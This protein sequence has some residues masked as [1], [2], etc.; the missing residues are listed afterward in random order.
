VR[1][2][3]NAGG[4]D[5][6]P[7]KDFDAARIHQPTH[8]PARSQYAHSEA[9]GQ[10]QKRIA[11]MATAKQSV[12]GP[13]DFEA[14]VRKCAEVAEFEA[15]MRVQQWR[16]RAASGRVA[17][18]LIRDESDLLTEAEAAEHCRVSK[19]TIARWRK[20]GVSN[21]AGTAGFKLPCRMV[22]R[23]PRYTR[24]QLDRWM[25]GIKRNRLE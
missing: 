22:G 7:A 3:K 24:K 14:Y 18:V 4:V 16:E 9:V 25:A 10:T 11:A 1:P 5:L 20:K 15:R 21:Q 17:P 19:Q 12:P 8:R 23:A 6:F 2:Q 13:D